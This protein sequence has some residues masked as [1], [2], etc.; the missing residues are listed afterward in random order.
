MS[1]WDKQITL[2]NT[3]TQVAADSSHWA[4]IKW[5]SPLNKLL[6]IRMQIHS[7]LSVY[8]EFI[9]PHD[10]FYFLLFFRLLSLFACIDFRVVAAFQSPFVILSRSTLRY[11]FTRVPQLLSLSE[12]HQFGF[13]KTYWRVDETRRINAL[14]RSTRDTSARWPAQLQVTDAPCNQKF[15]YDNPACLTRRGE[16]ERAICHRA[17]ESMIRLIVF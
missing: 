7:S 5:I 17:I 10:A 14:W 9:N 16:R 4:D 11:C 8:N 13:R 15:F 1:Y 3:I 6:A 12:L 2:I